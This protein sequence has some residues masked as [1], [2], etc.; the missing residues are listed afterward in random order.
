MLFVALQA[1]L[2]DKAWSSKIYNRNLL[3]KICVWSN[4]KDATVD[5][6]K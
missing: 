2:N 1:F 6:V 3:D 5:S 4:Q